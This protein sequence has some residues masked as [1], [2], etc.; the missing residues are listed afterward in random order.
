MYK[1]INIYYYEKTFSPGDKRMFD[2]QTAYL[3]ILFSK[4]KF[5]GQIEMVFNDDIDSPYNIMS[6]LNYAVDRPKKYNVYYTYTFTDADY[7]FAL[8]NGTKLEY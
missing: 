3:F 8:E 6:S 4:V 2:A 5:D 1:F 7:Q